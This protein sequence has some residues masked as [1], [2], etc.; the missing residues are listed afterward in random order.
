[1][2]FKSLRIVKS[3]E[4]EH[5]EQECDKILRWEEDDEEGCSCYYRP[6]GSVVIDRDGYYV[7]CFILVR[8]DM[9]DWD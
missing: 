1:M 9:E 2:G 8:M 5:F 3:D 7:M 6:Q 4:I